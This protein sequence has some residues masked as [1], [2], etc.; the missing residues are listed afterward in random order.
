M[1]IDVL[2]I[3]PGMFAGPFAEGM[4]RKAAAMGACEVRVHDLRLWGQGPHRVV[5][6]YAFG[7]GPGMVLQAGPVV[8]AVEALRAEGAGPP[9]LLS[10]QGRRLDQPLCRALAAEPA[11]TLICGRYEGVDERVRLALVPREV[12]I[13]DYVLTG[14]ELAAMVLVDA[15]VRLLPGVLAAGAAEDESFATGLLEGPQYTRPRAFRGMA[16]PEVLLGGDHGRIAAWRRVEALRRTW[17]H[18]PDLLAGAALT[19]ADARALARVVAEESVAGPVRTA[20]QRS[21]PPDLPGAPPGW[22]PR[23]GGVL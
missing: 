7:G 14:G 5:D 18:R 21:Q 9:L 3:F 1:R 17:R 13:G 20:E 22:A 6:D 11:L 8:A 12:S 10:P 16:V 15:L 2:T 23:P 4:V 19:A